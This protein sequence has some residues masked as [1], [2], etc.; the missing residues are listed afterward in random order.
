MHEVLPN[1]Q[2]IG[3]RVR[4]APQSRIQE[5]KHGKTFIILRKPYRDRPLPRRTRSKRYSRQTLA[6]TALPCT[7][8]LLQAAREEKRPTQPRKRARPSQSRPTAASKA[9][10]HRSKLQARNIRQT[11]E[12]C[13]RGTGSFGTSNRPPLDPIN[14]GPVWRAF[15]NAS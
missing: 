7:F 14:V 12:L 15:E 5:R 10:L 4:P 11:W 6:H 1:R 13:G 2:Q 8:S 9:F 3:L